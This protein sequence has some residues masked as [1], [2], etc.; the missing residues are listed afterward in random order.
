MAGAWISLSTRWSLSS[1][2]ASLNVIIS[3]MGT[4]GIW[5]FSRFWWQKAGHKVV[6]EKSEV[7]LAALYTVAAPGDAWDVAVVLG[8]R[9]FHR[10]NW[11]L[12]FQVIFVVTV[13]LGSIFSGPIAAATSR[14]RPTN[15]IRAL[16]VL[17]TVKQHGSPA[18]NL[19]QAIVLWNQTIKSLD[20]A[21]FPYDQ[22]LD[23]L[24][25]STANWTYISSEW[26]PTW[27]MDCDFTEET[28]LPN[29][30]GTGNATFYDPLNAFPAF[31]DTYPPR[32]LNKSEY[33]RQAEFTSWTSETGINAPFK[34]IILYFMIS[35]DPAVND[36]WK[37]NEE[38]FEIS[39]S[40]LHLHDVSALN[41]EFFN[42]QGKQ[43]WR[44]TGFVRNAS[45][46]RFE[47]SISRKLI[48]ANQDEVPFPWTNDTFSI[49]LEYAANWAYPFYAKEALNI[50]YPVP[51]AKQ[52][53]RFYQAYIL[54]IG[55]LKDPL[56][57]PRSLTVRLETVQIS[58]VFLAVLILAA[59]TITWLSARYFVFVNSHK[60]KLGEACV[61]DGK[62]EWIV[63]TAKISAAAGVD[64]QTSGGKPVKDRAYLRAA[65]FGLVALD[66]KAPGVEVRHPSLAR[67]QTRKQSTSEHPSHHEDSASNRPGLPISSVRS[68]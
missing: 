57:S 20:E 53:L 49:A 3:I 16:Q 2:Q 44:P 51:T 8:R 48:V 22:L 34:D 13:T 23:F 21:A 50:T 17:Q 1:V 9:L 19:L 36:R 29:L 24:P 65:T 31:R 40:A 11:S 47:C 7:P 66:A 67:V 46:T 56:S 33:R 68:E 35:S 39:M 28:I 15:Q 41:N 25:P 18:S 52:L 30:V 43:A 27:N 54:T 6:R 42:L 26:D 4:I 32:W 37:L 61:P 55:T 63:Y 45:Y 5:S 12:L 10:D 14:T 59:F 58:V 60:S 64:H 62:M 38:T